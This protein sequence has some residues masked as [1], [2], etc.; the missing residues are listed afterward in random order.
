MKKIFLLVILLLISERIFPQASRL[1]FGITNPITFLDTINVFVGEHFQ[2]TD[3]LS[4]WSPNFGDITYTLGVYLNMRMPG[5]QQITFE[6]NNGG[7][8]YYRGQLNY[9]SGSGI[10]LK[11]NVETGVNPGDYEIQISSDINSA[12]IYYFVG[13]IRG[14]SE[15]GGYFEDAGYWVVRCQP[16]SRNELAYDINLNDTYYFGES[17]YLDFSFPGEGMDKISNYYYRIFENNTEIFSGIGPLI[18]LGLV[19]KNTAMVNRSF[20]IEGYYGGKIVRFFNSAIP[21]PDSTIWSFKLLPPA[22]FEI[23]SKWMSK[24]IF[25]NLTNNDIIDALDMNQVENRR[26]KFQY[27][28]PVEKGAIVTTPLL[29][30]LSVTSTPPDFLVRSSNRYRVFDDGIWQVIEFNVNSR[31]LSDISRNSTKKIILHINF[32]TQFGEQKNFSF[33][34]FVF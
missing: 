29:R 11:S 4:D 20:T 25:D 13:I 1:S 32:T 26:I 30:N 27:F 24:D 2:I 7:F 10:G 34:G 23:D 17:V 14:R 15:R 6:Q 9:L 28:A 31:F 3:K 5:A 8:E 22:N 21:G 33:V 12:G 16:R 19:T 18:D